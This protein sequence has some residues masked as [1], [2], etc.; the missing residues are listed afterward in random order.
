M[1]NKMSRHYHE[2]PYLM[3][4]LHGDMA[5]IYS[6]TTTQCPLGSLMFTNRQELHYE[7]KTSKNASGLHLE[8]ERSSIEMI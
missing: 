8:L 1:I 5:E 2:N 6:R 7:A 3:Y 4:V